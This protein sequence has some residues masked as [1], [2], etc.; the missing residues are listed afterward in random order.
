MTGSELK[1][2]ADA[3]L[4]RLARWL[5]FL[6]YDTLYYPDISDA[7]LV[8]VA[9]EDDRIILTRDTRLVMMKGIGSHLLL[10]SD[11][12]FRQL[13]QVVDA[14]DPLPVKREG[15]CVQCNGKIRR[16]EDKASIRED[17]AD[18]VYLNSDSFFRCEDCGRIYWKGSHLKRFREK[19]EKGLRDM[20]KESLT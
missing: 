7:R 9:R 5:R 11:D 17:V 2:I 12:P 4:G 18:H 14:F 20:R 10:V 6:G 13:L 15:R 3:M 8:R 19:V 1:F 16:I